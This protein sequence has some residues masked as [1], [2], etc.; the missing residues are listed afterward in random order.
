MQD[1]IKNKLFY[2]I[3]ISNLH[4]FQVNV[5]LIKHIP[6]NFN[7]L[8]IKYHSLKQKSNILEY[9][10]NNTVGNFKM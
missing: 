10:I 2:K 5:N 1:D 8:A 7:I 4:I 9:I 6:S 3:E